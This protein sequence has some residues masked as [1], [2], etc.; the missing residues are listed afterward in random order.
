METAKS[1][2]RRIKENW[3]EKYCPIHMSGIDIGSRHDPVSPTFRCWDKCLGDGDATYMEGVPDGLFQTVYASHILEHLENPW[4]ALQNWWR[5]VRP[6]GHLIV[7]VPHR[8]LYEKR[9]EPPSLWN[10]EHKWFFLPD[11]TDNHLTINFTDIIKHILINSKEPGDIIHVRTLDENFHS[12][13]PNVHSV[14]EYSI[15]A[16]VHKR[17]PRLFLENELTIPKEMI[18]YIIS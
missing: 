8:E 3:F 1:Y 4:T 15:E 9:L 5:L 10:G 14:G 18:G 17:F 13:G 7:V 6:G 16:V 11:N 12:D 2:N